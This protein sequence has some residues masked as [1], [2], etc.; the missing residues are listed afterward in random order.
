[1]YLLQQQAITMQQW[2]AFFL[3]VGQVITQVNS[4][5]ST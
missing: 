4:V 3:F 2:V 1:M 5:V